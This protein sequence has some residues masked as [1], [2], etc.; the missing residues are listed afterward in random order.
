MIGQSKMNDT[1]PYMTPAGIVAICL[2]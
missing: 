1:L 2:F